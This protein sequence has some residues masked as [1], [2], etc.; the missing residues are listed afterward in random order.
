MVSLA[1]LIWNAALA[2]MPNC[3]FPNK[4]NALPH[5]YQDSAGANES[6]GLSIHCALFVTDILIISTDISV[7]QSAPLLV[8]L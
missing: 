6:Q 4:D 1:F 3:L 2:D 8:G 5:P 7:S